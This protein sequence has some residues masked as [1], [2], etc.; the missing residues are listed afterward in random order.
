M[1]IQRHICGIRY[2]FITEILKNIGDYSLLDFNLEVIFFS[3]F[4]HF[5]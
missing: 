4:L 5:L 3:I 2:A 1:Y